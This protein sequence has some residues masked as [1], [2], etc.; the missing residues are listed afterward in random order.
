VQ[1]MGG[2]ETPEDRPRT[3]L[4]VAQISQIPTF[5]IVWMFLFKGGLK[6]LRG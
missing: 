5:F 2:V 4:S 3:T 1:D 6:R